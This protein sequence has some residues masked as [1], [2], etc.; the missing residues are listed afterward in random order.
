LWLLASPAWADARALVGGHT[1]VNLDAGN[2][3]L[4]GDLVVPVTQV[5]P[6][7]Q[8]ALWPSFAHVFIHDTRDVNLLGVDVPFELRLDNPS[9]TPYFAPGLAL[10]MQ[11]G[12]QLKLN[13]IGGCFF[14]LGSRVHLF[15]EL[16]IRLVNGTYVDVLGGVLFAL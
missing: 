6:H 14:D 2:V 10:S 1:G 9:I 3:H 16:A 11:Y 15:T 8:L 12:V 7:V 13:L 5:S 4:G